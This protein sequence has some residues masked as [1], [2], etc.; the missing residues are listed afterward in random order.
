MD[1]FVLDFIARYG[2]DGSERRTC[3]VVNYAIYM[4]R[5]WKVHKQEGPRSRMLLRKMGVTD[6][7]AHE[8]VERFEFAL[9]LLKDDTPGEK[10]WTTS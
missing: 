4:L 3:V 2:T 1:G 7:N 9:A 6:E 5:L 10:Q 8:Y